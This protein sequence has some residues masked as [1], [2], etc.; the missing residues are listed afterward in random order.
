MKGEMNVMH[1]IHTTS[2]VHPTT[3]ADVILSAMMKAFCLKYPRDR[4][5]LIDDQE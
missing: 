5:A 1:R 3:A 2:P 4:R